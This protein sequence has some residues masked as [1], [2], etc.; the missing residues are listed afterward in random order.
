MVRYDK[1]KHLSA[2]R[3]AYK[4][5]Q[6]P[7][8][9]NGMPLQAR[10]LKT[11]LLKL[12]RIYANANDFVQNKYHFKNKIKDIVRVPTAYYYGS[13][14]DKIK[15]T[16]LA[17]DEFVIK[18]NHLSQGL[19]IRVLKRDGSAFFDI[20]GEILSLDD[21]L[22]ECEVILT[23]NRLKA[24]RKI[25]VEERIRS[26]PSF[27]CLGDFLVDVRFNFYR[28]RFLWGTVRIPN[29][30]SGGYSNVSKGAE[31]CF[32]SENGHY[33]DANDYRFKKHGNRSG[34][35]PFFSEMVQAGIKVTNEFGLLYQTVDM[36]V[37]EEEEVVVIES[38]L[39][40]QMEKT[41]TPAGIAWMNAIIEKDLIQNE[42]KY[43]LISNA[44][45]LE[46]CLQRWFHK[47]PKGM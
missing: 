43:K 44:K 40:S 14:L 3:E 46:R 20:N 5:E 36:T 26:H 4:K 32:V 7:G 29:R 1:A 27:D 9:E 19:G 39:L 28:N 16:L 42:L 34:R 23:I 25:I 12:V 18:P 47:F 30:K 22:D 33:M 45:R 31:I 37:N 38:E 24:E 13:D 17:L 35:L 6:S 8:F 2:I 15:K 21:I 10:L 41:L 11:N